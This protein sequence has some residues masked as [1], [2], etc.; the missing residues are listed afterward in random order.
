MTGEAR[1]AVPGESGQ[2][3]IH[4]VDVLRDCRGP[5]PFPR[6]TIDGVVVDVSGD[7]YVDHE[8][9][10]VDHEAQVYVLLD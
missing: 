9:Q 6:G 10:V 4:A 5:F 7:R 1:P 3:Y 2:Q 8:A